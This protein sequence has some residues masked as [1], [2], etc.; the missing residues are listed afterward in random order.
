M[1]WPPHGSNPQYLYAAMD[2]PLPEKRI[3]FS[4]NINPIGPPAELKE[5][6]GTL[7]DFITDY[8]DPNALSLKKKLALAAGVKDTQI[9]VGNGGAE[10]IS[11]IAR[12]MAGKRVLIVQP[13]FSEYEAACKVNGCTITYHQLESDTWCLNMEALSLKLMNADAVFFC[14][15]N[16]PTG[17]YYPESA[18]KELIEACMER[19]CLLVIDE[20]FYDFVK[21]YQS[22]TPYIKNNPSIMI[23]RSMTKMFAV[24][25]LRLGYLLANEELIEKVSAIQPHW[26]VNALAL[27]AGEWCLEGEQ[28]LR[29]TR[30]VIQMEKERLFLFYQKHNFSVSSTDVNFYLLKDPVLDD[31]LPLFQYL[32]EKGIIPRHTMNFPGLRGKWLRFAI[33]APEN[34]DRLMEAMG[35]WRES[36]L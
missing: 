25:G 17:I 15:P 30:E 24:P 10:L 32:L 12:M 28:H 18:V 6:W 29:L 7:I 34:N 31:Q 26:S 3:D 19:H 21:D 14:N 1:K 23:L 4:A 8:P 33:K 16:N 35:E 36:H 5:R 11:L 9:L 27:K 2:M 22:I 13:A 20:A